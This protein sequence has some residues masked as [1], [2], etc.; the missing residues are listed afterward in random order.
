MQSAATNQA[1]QECIKECTNCHTICEYTAAYCL[2][3][4]GPHAAPE[5]Q[6]I[7]R[8]CAQICHVSADFMLR[9]S[10]LHAAVCGVCAQVCVQCA[11][12]CERIGGG[13]AQMKACADLCRRC[14][15]SCR[16]MAQ[17]RV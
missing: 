1:M 3:L 13:D 12:S 17:A 5:H 16:Q 11:E 7:L 6:R 10:P 14:A 9:G 2:Q 4:G 15:E 8:D